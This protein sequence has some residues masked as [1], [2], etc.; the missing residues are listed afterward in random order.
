MFLL[1]FI[2]SIENKYPVQKHESNFFLTLK[3]KDSTDCNYPRPFATTIKSS[4]TTASPPHNKL[5]CLLGHFV[6]ENAL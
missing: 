1:V 2:R 6:R 5:I 3:I 4:L